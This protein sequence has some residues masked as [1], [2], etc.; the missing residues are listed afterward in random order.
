MIAIPIVPF[1]VKAIGVGAI[2][3]GLILFGFDYKGTKDQNKLLLTQQAE[4]V[5][6]IEK[7]EATSKRLDELLTKRDIQHADIRTSV[8]DVTVRLK[9][10]AANDKPTS[11]F[12]NTTLPNG[13]RRAIIETNAARAAAQHTGDDSAGAYRGGA[14]VK[15]GTSARPQERR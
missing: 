9:Q 5:A 14:Q 7:V 12:L 15:S 10:E 11:N 2:A 8:A 3:I 13:M 4:Y 1:W 6:R